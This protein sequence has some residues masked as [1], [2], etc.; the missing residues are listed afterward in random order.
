METQST[1]RV[2]LRAN[3]TENLLKKLSGKA[4]EYEQKQVWANAGIQW[5]HCA[6]L[7]NDIEEKGC[8]Y[9][10][11]FFCYDRAKHAAKAEEMLRTCRKIYL[12]AH[13]Y[14]AADF[15]RAEMDRHNAETASRH[16]VS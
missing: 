2:W 7:T 15:C 8:Y 12:R 4:F 6:K 9:Y 11:A 5:E 13:K 10:S 3:A 1:D 14:T 16:D